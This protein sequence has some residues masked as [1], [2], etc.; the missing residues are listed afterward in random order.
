[1]GRRHITRPSCLAAFLRA[2]DL[3]GAGARVRGYDPAVAA[4][5]PVLDTGS[6]ECIQ[7]FV[8]EIFQRQDSNAFL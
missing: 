4:A 1:M 5:G 7:F 6:E 3:A 8:A 2:A